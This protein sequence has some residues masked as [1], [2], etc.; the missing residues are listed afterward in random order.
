MQSKTQYPKEQVDFLQAVLDM[1][2][3]QRQYFKQPTDYR[4]KVSL[5]KEQRVDA[6]LQPFIN[7]RVIKKPEEP[8]TGQLTLI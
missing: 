3:A 2:E 5:K 4:L 8:N 6:L 7:E 1:R